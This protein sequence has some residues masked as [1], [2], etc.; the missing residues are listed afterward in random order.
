[1]LIVFGGLPG[2][3]KTTIARVVAMAISATY[4]RIDAIEQAIRES[5]VLAGAVGPSGYAAAQAIAE[6][7]LAIGRTVVADCV[8]PVRASRDGWRAVA[9]RAGSR[10]LEV[11]IVCS[12]PA[13]HRRRI[14]AR[15]ADIPGLSPPSWAEVRRYDYERWDR[16]RLIVDTATLPPTEAAALVIERAR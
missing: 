5:G 16:P 1:M 11:E 12:D 13:E 2:T 14:T 8:N 3:G 7:N 6:G 4:L 9:A 10:L 15:T